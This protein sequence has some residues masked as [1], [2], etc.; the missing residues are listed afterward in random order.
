MKKV[1]KIAGIVLLVIIIVLVVAFTI[2]WYRHIHW[3]DKYEKALKKAEAQ[4]KQ[5]TLPNGN[6]V[7]LKMISQH[8]C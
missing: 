3:Y 1:M 7:K 5:I 2:Y 4:E 8:C 6:V